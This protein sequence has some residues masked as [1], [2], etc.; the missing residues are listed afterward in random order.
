MGSWATLVRR[1]TR[2][3]ARYVEAQPDMK[4]PGTGS[5]HTATEPAGLVQ[6]FAARPAV[7]AAV[8]VANTES[9][10]AV[11]VAA[12]GGLKS[13]SYAALGQLEPSASGLAQQGAAADE[14]GANGYHPEMFFLAPSGGRAE[15]EDRLASPRMVWV[16]HTTCRSSLLWAAASSGSRGADSAAY[17]M[18]IAELGAG[19]ASSSMARIRPQ[20]CG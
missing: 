8:V 5:G 10:A 9:A 4:G 1:C 20:A 16:L 13:H 3:F 12:A 7:A 17:C 18:K 6:S 14:H 11:A 2:G 15:A 19:E